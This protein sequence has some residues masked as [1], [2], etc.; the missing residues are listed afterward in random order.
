MY[1][2]KDAQKAKE[3]QIKQESLELVMNYIRLLY[4]PQ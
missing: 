4:L 1:Q 3:N 2:L